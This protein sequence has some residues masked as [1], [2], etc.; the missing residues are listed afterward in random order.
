[1]PPVV[2]AA[3][4]AAAASLTAA[5]M[6]SSAAGKATKAQTEANANALTF[7][8]EQEA[9]RRAR[10]QQGMQAYMANRKLLAQHLGIELPDDGAA[11]FVG[12]GGARPMVAPRPA[13]GGQWKPPQLASAD[14]PMG[15]PEMEFGG[16]VRDLIPEEARFG[17][18]SPYWRA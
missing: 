12:P 6:G 2:I 15:R 11:S 3:G 10:Y 14:I 17:A 5:K 18:E 16:S 1:M 9:A 4:I 13:M 7:A 8:R